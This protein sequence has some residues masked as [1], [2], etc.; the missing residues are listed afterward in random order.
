MS[1]LSLSLE[2]LTDFWCFQGV[3]K[4]CIGSKW[5][6][7]KKIF[8]QSNVSKSSEIFRK[9]I[10]FIA[11]FLFVS[12]WFIGVLYFSLFTISKPASWKNMLIIKE[13]EYY[14]TLKVWENLKRYYYT[15]RKCITWTFS[16]VTCTVYLCT[17]LKGFTELNGNLYLVKRQYSNG[18]LHA[19]TYYCI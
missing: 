19:L 14:S 1:T 15:I 7:C 11:V 2:N 5:V 13:W 17:N 10:R 4:G 16:V 3:E 12:E 18:N 9:K 6:N 8:F